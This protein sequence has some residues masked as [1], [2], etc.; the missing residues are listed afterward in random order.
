MLIIFLSPGLFGFIAVWRLRLTT[1]FDRGRESMRYSP[2]PYLLLF[3]TGPSQ[4]SECS[5]FQA[6]RR[7]R[8]KW[9]VRMPIARPVQVS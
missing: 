4:S 1:L 8:L 3:S 7:E 6:H 5:P 2:Q 9:T